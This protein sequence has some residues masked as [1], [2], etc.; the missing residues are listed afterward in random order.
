[1]VRVL[2]LAPLPPPVT[3]QSLACDAFLQH[4]RGA[5]TVDVVNLMKGHHRNGFTPLHGLRIPGLIASTF[6]LARTADVVYMNL[7]Q[8]L[9]GNVKD[10]GLLTALGRRIE[11]TVVHLQGGGIGRTVYGRSKI[12]KA[13]NTRLLKHVAGVVVL[14]DSLRHVFQDMVPSERVHVV[15]NFAADDLFRSEDEIRAKFSARGP[16]RVLFLGNLHRSK[17]Y[18][19]LL[20][21]AQHVP[22]VEFDIAGAFITAA[23][24]CEDE[25]RMRALANV[26]YHGVVDGDAKRRLL[27]RAHV[28]CLPTWYPYEGQPLSILEAY[29]SGASVITTDHGGIPD[30]FADGVNGIQ[31]EIRS[32]DA[33]LSAIR[34]C[35]ADRSALV[36]VA[37]RNRSAAAGFTRRNHVTELRRILMDVRA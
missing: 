37:L 5:D 13:V 28:F 9:S 29:A 16:L 30:V 21:I 34:A 6:R 14:G 12:L 11:R 36:E 26:T 10:L 20:D 1:M 19:L 31:V 15:P 4:L 7:A 27:A 18:R 33:L 17:G 24:H 23:E 8:S 2:Y 22:D 3:G 32:S 35:A 25:P